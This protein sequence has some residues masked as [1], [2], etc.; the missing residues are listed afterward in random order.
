LKTDQKEIV[1]GVRPVLELLHAGK[2]VE[3]ILLQRDQQGG[4]INELMQEAARLKIP[5]VRVPVEKLNSFTRKNHQGIIAFVSPIIYAS[6]DNIVTETFAAGKNPLLLI[7]DR[8]TDV[9]NFGAI[10]RTAECM[11]VNALV[12]PSRGSAMINSDA[13]KTSAGAL[14]YI[15]VCREEN[16]KNTVTYLRESGIILAACTEKS[17]KLIYEADFSG[18]LAIIMGSE[19]NGISDEYLKRCDIKVKIPQL[20]KIESLNVSVATG[21]ILSEAIRQRI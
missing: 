19:E 8:V 1:F 13:V 20:G 2:E 7:L 17:D 11:G 15:P 10:A 14:S 18:P 6:L 16:L 3:K 21:I 12:I 4:V 9:R 5:L